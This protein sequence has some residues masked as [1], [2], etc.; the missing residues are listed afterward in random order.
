MPLETGA[1][2][3]DPE[4]EK[5]NPATGTFSLTGELTTPRVKPKFVTLSDGRALLL[6]GQVLALEDPLWDELNCLKTSARK[7]ELYDSTSGTFSTTGFAHVNDSSDYYEGAY[8]PRPF[9]LLDDNR[10]FVVTGQNINFNSEY[11]SDPPYPF[12][13]IQALSGAENDDGIHTFAGPMAAPH[14]GGV[15]QKLGNGL[16]LVA[17]GTPT[18]PGQDLEMKVNGVAELFDQTKTP[19]PLPRRGFRAVSKLK[20]TPKK[21]TIR[22]GK[23]GTFKVTFLNV[24]DQYLV[25]NKVCSSVASKNARHVR[26]KKCNRANRIGPGKTGK[27]KFTVFVKKK[28]KKGKRIPVKFVLKT[29]T[30][31][32]SP[33]NKTVIAK[34][35]IK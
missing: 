20:V 10:I 35:K 26:L 17:G 21:K 5:Y 11:A 8:L 28:A 18:D 9:T 3:D 4:S 32:G 31:T 2:W 22:R 1:G 30:D 29:V 23:K 24:G 12:A 34:V 19:P 15:V 13:Y 27:T 6:G 33:K 7:A 16:V 25:K 14:F